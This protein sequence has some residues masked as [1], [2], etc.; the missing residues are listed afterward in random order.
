MDWQHRRRSGGSSQNQLGHADALPQKVICF[1]SRRPRRGAHRPCVSPGWR[2]LATCIHLARDLHE[3]SN[4]GDYAKRPGSPQ[5]RT[6]T[7][8]TTMSYT[9]YMQRNARP[10]RREVATH[11]FFVGQA[12]R[13]RSGFG[14]FSKT[15]EIYHITGKLPPRG[16]S[17]QYRIRNDEERHE[18]VTTQDRIEPVQMLPA[19]EDA[20]LIE[21][22]FGHGQRA[23]TQQPRDQEA[24]TGKDIA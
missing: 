4:T 7:G 8:T 11:L 24:E 1:L 21:R 15:A 19:G 10:I 5:G 22:T 2:S 23:E 13:L 6:G 17:P 20:T 18:R 9:N 16:D 12:V 3:G 14:M